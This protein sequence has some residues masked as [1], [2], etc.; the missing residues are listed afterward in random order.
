MP[1]TQTTRNILVAFVALIV[2]LLLG[3]FAWKERTGIAAPGKTATSTSIAITVGP[4]I[5]ATTTSGY[6]ITPIYATSTPAAQAPNYK[7]PLTFSSDI[8]AGE[9]TVYQNQFATIQT[10]LASSPTDYSSWLELGILREETG[11][12]QGAAAD[13]K[14]VTKVYPTDPTA[15]ANLGD[16]YANYLKQPSQGE[17]YYKQAIALDPT[18]EATFY[19][20]LAQIY[21]AQGDTADAKATLQQGINA[22]VIGY[23][24]LQTELNSMQ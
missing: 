7:T 4:S 16:L 11:D 9:Q 18:K 23:Q 17:A 8:S 5:E 12:Y 21:A 22:Q 10:T 1:M 6:T 24:N 19:E 20:N 14:Y 13:W 15:Y 2:I 3:Y